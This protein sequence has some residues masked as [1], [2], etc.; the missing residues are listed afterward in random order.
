[1][2]KMNKP[3]LIVLVIVAIVFFFLGLS[4]TRAY[5]KASEGGT[6]NALEPQGLDP[7]PTEEDPMMI[8]PTEAQGEIGKTTTV[9]AKF[10][11]GEYDTTRWLL[12]VRDSNGIVC[13]GKELKFTCY[14]KIQTMYNSKEFVLERDNII[15]WYVTITPQKGAATNTPF[16]FNISFCGLE[17]NETDCSSNSLTYSDTFVLTVKKYSIWEFFGIKR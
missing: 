12:K 3:L 10:Y 14:P 8:T 13:P 5:F 1:M 17:E 6:P 11:N 15:G 2:A 7:R 4:F 16:S 9:I